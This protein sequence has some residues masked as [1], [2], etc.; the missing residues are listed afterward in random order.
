MSY[1]HSMIEMKL[2]DQKHVTLSLTAYG[3]RSV[4]TGK[5]HWQTKEP[6]SKPEIICVYNKLVGGVDLKGKLLKYS[7]FS[8]HHL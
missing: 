5:K 8:R 2:L 1:N 4:N 6:I 7:A 3:S